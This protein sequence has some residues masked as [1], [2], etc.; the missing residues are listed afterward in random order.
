MTAGSPSVMPFEV[1]AF[2][3]RL[4]DECRIPV[5]GDNGGERRERETGKALR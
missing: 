1:A 4:R 2:F 5:R 3:E